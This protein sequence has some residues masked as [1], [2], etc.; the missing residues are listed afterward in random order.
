MKKFLTAMAFMTLFQAAP[1]EA[2]AQNPVGFG[3]LYYE[4][5]TV[6]TVVPPASS[7]ME[8][9]ENFYAVPNQ[10]A[11]IATAPGDKNYRGGKWAF[12]TVMVN[13][14]PGLLTSETEVLAAAVAGD[15]S[16]MRVPTMDFKCPV[17]P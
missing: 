5:T 3:M 12:H 17:Q 10:M 11:V 13:R 14:D 7:P 15:I 9:R 4:G 16:I 6:G 8:G 2:Q 1:L